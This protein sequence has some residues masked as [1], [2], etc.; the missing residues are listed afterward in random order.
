MDWAYA[1]HADLERAYPNQW[2]AIVDEQVVAA[3]PDLGE[4]ESQAAEVTD[5][6]D[7]AILF[8]EQGIHVWTPLWPP[9]AAALRT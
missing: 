5:R 6:F 8:V 4:V 2:V 7:I 1:N 3:G 9:G